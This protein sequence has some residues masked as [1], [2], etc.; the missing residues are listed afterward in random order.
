MIVS[1]IYHW[2]FVW[3]GVFKGVLFLYLNVHC[4]VILRLSEIPQISKVFVLD[5]TYCKLLQKTK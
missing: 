4:K 1:F 3:I 5:Y 2:G